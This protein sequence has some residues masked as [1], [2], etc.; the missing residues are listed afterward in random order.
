MLSVAKPFE[1]LL[2]VALMY[3]LIAFIV[4]IILS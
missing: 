4:I 1:F 3:Y 2:T